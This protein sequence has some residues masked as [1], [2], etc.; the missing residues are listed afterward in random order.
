[1]LEPF[2]GLRGDGSQRG[3]DD[4]ESQHQP[5]QATPRS[6]PHS[7]QDGKQRGQWGQYDDEVH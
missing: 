5:D 4:G 1:M 3:I 7:T 6:W 2:T